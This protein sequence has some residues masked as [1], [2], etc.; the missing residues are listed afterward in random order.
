MAEPFRTRLVDR[1]QSIKRHENYLA[2]L[3]CLAI[4]VAAV[5]VITIMQ[6]AEALNHTETVLDCPYV[7]DGAHTHNADCYDKSGTLVCPLEERELHVHDDS[8]Y[9]EELILICGFEDG[10]E[11]AD[12]STHEHTDECYEVERT[13]TCDKEEVTEEHI[14]GQGCFKTVH[15]YVEDEEAETDYDPSYESELEGEPTEEPE[16]EGSEGEATDAVEE[17]AETDEAEPES[18]KGEKV[19]FREELLDD[20][21]NVL[22]KVYVEAPEGAFPEGATMQVT[23]II[24]DSVNSAVE[25]AVSSRTQGKITQIQSVDITF[26]DSYGTEIEPAEP[27]SVKLTSPLIKGN[28]STMVV[29]VDN[30]GQGEVVDTLTDEELHERNES[31]EPDAVSFESGS[32]SPYSIVALDEDGNVVEQ[33]MAA[34]LRMVKARLATMSRRS[35]LHDKTDKGNLNFGAD[36][37]STYSIVVT[38]FEQTLVASDRG[39]YRVTV[40]CPPEAG[41]PEGSS[42]QVG[43]VP[44]AS[45][46]YVRY[47][48]R[49]S[50][51]LPADERIDTARFFD[52]SIVHDGQIVQPQAAV[53]VQIELVDELAAS[54]DTE[55]RVVHFAD[56]ETTPEELPVAV[57]ESGNM[58]VVSFEA[59]SFSVYAVVTTTLEQSVLASDGNTYRVSVTYGS[60]AM[61]PSGT[62]L[63]VSELLEG[64]ESY[65]E[66]IERT[67]RALSNEENGAAAVEQARLFDISLVHDGQTIEPAAPVQ[68]RIEYD[69][70][71][72][73]EEGSSFSIVHFADED[74]AEAEA[75]AEVL[76]PVLED[77]K[78]DEVSAFEFETESFSTFAFARANYVGALGGYSF[79]LVRDSG[80][81]KVA[82]LSSAHQKNAGRMS[83]AW[84][85]V[86]EDG[87]LTSVTK[88][89][90][91]VE[92]DT[93]I[94]AW[95]FEHVKEN[96][97]YLKSD[98]GVY[99]SMKG[100][101]IK[102]EADKANA[103]L[104]EVCPLTNKG[105][106]TGKVRLR[107]AEDG[108][109]INL[110]RGT[111]DEGFQGSTSTDSN[112]T[113]SLYPSSELSVFETVT[114]RKLSAVDLKAGQS[115]A[116]YRRLLNEESGEYELYVVDGNGKLI[117]AYDDGDIVGYR[118]NQ[119][120]A[121]YVIEHVDDESGNPN[122]YYD[123][124]NEETGVFLS[125]SSSGILSER[126]PG[127]RLEGK[128]S[129]RA[130]TTI[131]AWDEAS[132]AYCGYQ[133]D[134]EKRMLAPGLGSESEEFSFA[135]PEERDET[136]LHE[137]ATVD[138]VADG[139]TIKMYDF[140]SRASMNLFN[141]DTWYQYGDYKQGLLQRT[142]GSDGMPVSATGKSLSQ[143]YNSAN[144]KG[145]ANHLFL[146]SI[147]DST[148]YYEYNSFENYAYYNKNTHDFTVYDEKGTPSNGSGGSVSSYYRG[149]Y[150]PYNTIDPSRPAINTKL[151]DSLEGMTSLENPVFDDQMYLTNGTNNYFFGTTVEA[152]FL[153]AKDGLD[154][155]GNPI[156]YEFYG[157]DDL[158]VFIDGVLVLDL[159]GIHSTAAGSIDFSTGAVIAGEGDYVRPTTIKQC[160]KE[161]G[162]FPDGT[163]WNEALV[164]N[165]FHGDTFNDYSGHTMKMFYQERGAGASTLKVRFNLP[166]VESGTFAVEKQ[167][168]G[169]NQ[170]GYA[171]V[172]FAYQAFL[173]PVGS[174]PVCL[175]PGLIIDGEG[176]V[177]SE[178]KATADQKDDPV[179]VVYESSGTD[180]NFY[181]GVKIGE[182]TYDGV[183]YLKPGEAATFSGISEGVKYYVQEIDVSGAY[184]ETVMI[185]EADMG[186]EGGIPEDDAVTAKSSS[187][188]I[189]ERQRLLFKNQ[190]SPRNMRDLRITK[191]VDNPID[192]GATFEFRVRLEGPDGG[193][194]YYKQGEYY[195]VHEVDGEDHYFIHANGTVVDQGTEPVV[196]GVSGPYGTIA[197]VPDGYTVVIKGLLAGTDFYVDEIRNPEGYQQVA[198]RLDDGTYDAAEVDGADGRIKLGQDA[199]ETIVNHRY[200]TIS[201]T[202]QWE[203]GTAV[204][205]HGNLYVALYQ[206]VDGQEVLAEKGSVL[207]SDV[208][209][210]IAAPATSAT[211]YLELPTGATL[212]DY[213]VR[214][215]SVEGTGDEQIVTPLFDGDTLVVQGETMSSDDDLAP[216][217]KADVRYSVAYAPGSETIVVEGDQNI[218]SRTDAVA[219]AR[220][221]LVQFR[222]VDVAD[223]DRNLSGAEFAMYRV[224]D[225]VQ[226]D[227]P[228]YARLVSGEDGLLADGDETSLDL[229]MGTYHL[230][231]TVP[232]TGYIIRD[233]PV[234]VVVSAMGV[235]YDEG[236]TAIGSDGRGVSLSDGIYTLKVTNS[237]GYALPRTGGRGTGALYATGVLLVAG[238]V[239]SLRRRRARV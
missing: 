26:Y 14:H 45:R 230:V 234:V 52:I 8:C 206:L 58:S 90:G 110:K 211:W 84:V 237:G 130:N 128:A 184:Y 125:P 62:E 159:G 71:M 43:E 3:A 190:C 19:V 226:E 93:P 10:E 145:E 193:L 108:N 2:L 162:V 116:I 36:S 103:T 20:E 86:L 175:R 117:Y 169:T 83:G 167:L 189:Q 77:E 115:V 119:S 106:L 24:D 196:C 94:T 165:Y 120:T 67:A 203:S 180:V 221:Q 17:A 177:V 41:I 138:S 132:W 213:V 66:Y 7:G 21:G 53:A 214:E 79:A 56:G 72:P 32:F 219:N 208:V 87:L 111:P 200:S 140:A 194:T 122:G 149:N 33:H 85:N 15:T 185:N 96:L 98:D 204:A 59:E 60:E 31:S 188:T 231:E 158:W 104:I 97:Y 88:A 131:E 144:F 146:Q 166:V 40:D 16:V 55:V 229:S 174:D 114:A 107:S 228:I 42:L 49:V 63:V 178:S 92:S 27:I 216:D 6:H 54:T 11:L 23:P 179:R 161:A 155:S 227:D 4:V 50:D 207:C 224:V 191:E 202:K 235:T 156:V 218:R 102:P 99:L 69:D 238:S 183:F 13:L 5:V 100:A 182:K 18:Q 81:N 75:E 233:K 152:N 215:V 181:D 118:T 124:Y 121:W 68:V 212:E 12:G 164:D 51:Q 129:A 123:F 142:L 176:K 134:L 163:A 210:R 236:I 199:R 136:K 133:L 127:V 48:D 150:M 44:T 28:R 186:G 195:L 61:I 89:N 46:K 91:N 22:I 126:A 141:N 57:G 147:Y 225:G 95:T 105:A 37:F 47:V 157:D 198:K 148:G 232:P 197:G 101:T 29:H 153:Q 135:L 76:E 168:G 109:Y 143:I 201:I 187:K 1:V 9:T 73:L 70:A 64:T 39:T 171:N 170:Q 74:K 78:T 192:D 34:V 160:F 223:L 220:E 217:Q 38:T 172:Q 65:D 205:R 222:K 112:S 173:E 25:E 35:S 154:E 209:Q 30:T 113:F 82:L 137:V 80:Q 151:Y 139:I 239:A